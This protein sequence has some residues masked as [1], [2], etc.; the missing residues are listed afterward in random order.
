MCRISCQSRL[1]LKFQIWEV[2]C[3]WVRSWKSKR[4]RDQHSDKAVLKKRLLSPLEVLIKCIFSLVQVCMGWTR[5]MHDY[6]RALPTLSPKVWK[7][8]PSSDAWCWTKLTK[9]IGPEVNESFKEEVEAIE[10]ESKLCFCHRPAGWVFVVGTSFLWM[11][12]AKPRVIHL[13]L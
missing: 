5:F 1:P 4:T 10:I 11:F 13:I 12:H 7:H 6:D 2:M 3:N 9:A 8:P